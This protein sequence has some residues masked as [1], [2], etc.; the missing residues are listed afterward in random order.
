M[1]GLTYNQIVAGPFGYYPFFAE[2]L[3]QEIASPMLFTRKRLYRNQLSQQ[4]RRMLYIVTL[5]NSA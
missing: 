4:F 5:H 3:C 1:K 2:K